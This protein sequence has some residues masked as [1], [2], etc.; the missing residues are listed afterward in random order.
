MSDCI[1][2]KIVAGDLP[3][4]QVYEDECYLCFMD[5]NPITTGHCL[6]IP[7]AHYPDVYAMPD[8]LLG[9]LMVAAKRIAAAA[10]TSLKADG[11]NLLQSNGRAANQL[12]DHYHLHLLP[13]WTGD[14]VRVGHWDARPSDGEAIRAAAEKIRG[15]L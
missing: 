14:K 2:C 1:F 5:I 6:L 15:A 4:T 11:L 12:V 8:D 13:R 7:K 9:G 3:S 10:K